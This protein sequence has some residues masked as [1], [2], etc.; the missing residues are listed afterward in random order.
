MN[1]ALWILA[2]VLAAVF[3]AAGGMKLGQPKAALAP[4][5]AW[6]N[7]VSEG[8]VKAI[9]LLEVLGAVGVVLPAAVDIA[10]ILVPVA[11][12]GLALVMVGAVVVHLRR[13]D[14]PGV[15]AAP[16]VLGLLAAALAIGRFG[17]EAF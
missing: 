11:A 17:P 8:Q 7:D 4:K 2:G 12:T 15:A 9:G 5:M 6:V 16:A 3:L 1:L 13:G 10:P 14:G